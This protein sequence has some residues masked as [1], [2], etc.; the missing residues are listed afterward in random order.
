MDVVQAVE[1]AVVADDGHRFSLEAHLPATAARARLLWLPALG[2]SARHYRPF[3]QALAAHGIAVYLHEWRGHGSSSLRARRGVDWGYRELLDD[4]RASEA[5]CDAQLPTPA[6]ILGGHSLG[7]QLACCRLGLDPQAADAVWLVASGT[8]FWRNFPPATRWWL[9]LA[10]RFLPWLARC[11]GHL[12]GR[13]I[14]FGGNEAAGVMADWGRSG[15]SGRYAPH[16]I[17]ADLEAGMARFDGQ[18]R[19]IALADDWLGPMASLVHL[20]HKLT[21]TRAE[22]ATLDAAN[23]GAP[24]DHNGWMRKPEAVVAALVQSIS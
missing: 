2:V 6:R 19:G 24:A 12:P 17:D 13:R 7:G 14:G 1:L 23:L 3:A 16:G 9:P 10:Y 21:N 18:L 11:V 22:L 4:I 15:L 20:T 8:P 5:T